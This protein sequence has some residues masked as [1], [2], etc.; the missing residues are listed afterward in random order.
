MY[1]ATLVVVQ[2]GCPISEQEPPGLPVVS[3]LP[4]LEEKALSEH[5]ALQPPLEERRRRYMYVSTCIPYKHLFIQ[6]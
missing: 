4:L 5:P 2:V 6:D 1:L 3:H